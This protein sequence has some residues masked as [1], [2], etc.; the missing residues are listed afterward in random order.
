MPEHDNVHDQ[1]VRDALGNEAILATRVEPKA[2]YSIF[3][4][5]GTALPDAYRPM[6][7]SKWLR[8]LRYGNPYFK[9]IAPKAYWSM[10]HAYITHILAR[11]EIRI[12]ALTDDPD[13]SLGFSSSRPHILDYVH[14]HRDHRH[15]GIARKLI[16]SGVTM[17]THITKTWELI[18]DKHPEW[19]FNP[20]A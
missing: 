15:C 12:A 2:S 8:S 9:M 3:V 6:I 18:W 1:E 7:Y 11:S 13:V 19:E 14:V 4:Y 16:P 10:Y 5:P 17:F 20:F